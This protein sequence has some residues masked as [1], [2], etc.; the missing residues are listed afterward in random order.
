MNVYTYNQQLP[1]LLWRRQCKDEATRTITILHQGAWFRAHM[2]VHG[3]GLTHDDQYQQTAEQLDLHNSQYEIYI[4]TLLLYRGHYTLEPWHL[5][6][7][8]TIHIR[9]TNTWPARPTI[10]TRQTHPSPDD[11]TQPP[12]RKQQ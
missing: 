8:S 10:L 6:H 4:N 7:G 2:L 12:P 3:P 5:A 9:M 11:D 1:H